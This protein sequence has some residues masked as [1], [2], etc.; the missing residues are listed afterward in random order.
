[1]RGVPSASGRRA[2]KHIPLAVKVEA[3]LILLG[4]EPGEAI[5]WDHNPALG[6]RVFNEATDDYEPAELDPRFLRPLRRAAHKAKTN[7]RKGTKRSTSYG[8][9]VH[10]IAKAKRVPAAFEEFRSRLLKKRPGK[11]APKPASKFRGGRKL[12][13]RGFEKRRVA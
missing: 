10:A 4:F 9:D 13:S 3:C 6:L 5:D 12:R 2:R 8:S 1:M 11:P 7:G